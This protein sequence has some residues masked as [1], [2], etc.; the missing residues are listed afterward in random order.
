MPILTIASVLLPAICV[1]VG[2]LLAMRNSGSGG[3]GLGN[4]VIFFFL[5]AVGGALAAVCALLALLRRERW[6]PLQAIVLLANVAVALFVGVLLLRPSPAPIPSGPPAYLRLAPVAE[7]VRPEAIVLAYPV[8]PDSA[9]GQRFPIGQRDSSGVVT[10]VRTAELGA[11]LG[12]GE[13]RLGLDAVD[14]RWSVGRDGAQVA[15]IPER[16]WRRGVY[17]EIRVNLMNVG[18]PIGLS[19]RNFKPLP[20]PR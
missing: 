10:S 12:P 1:G 17:L 16:D 5:I 11:P 15:K 18:V 14:G 19:D 13:V 20:S 7:R 4:I 2:H 8:T 6:R 9:E 3:W